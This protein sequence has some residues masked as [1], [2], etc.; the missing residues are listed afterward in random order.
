M[1][2]SSEPQSTIMSRLDLLTRR[3]HE[4]LSLENWLNFPVIV[5]VS[6]GPDSVALLRWVHAVRLEHALPGSNLIVAHFNHRLRG[7]DSDADQQFVCKL[8]E[9]LGGVFRN[10]TSESNAGRAEGDLRNARYQ[11]LE[12]LAIQ[13]GARLIATGHTSDDQAETVLF[14]L[15]RGSGLRGLAGI[16]AVRALSSTTTL[17]RPLLK[18]SRLEV[19]QLL[20][21]LQQ[22]Y[23]I[24]SSNAELDYTRNYL[25]NSLIPELQTRFP[26]SIQEALL[27]ISQQAGETLDFLDLQSEP[28]FPAVLEQSPNHL[29]LDI[30]QWQTLHPTLLKHFLHRLWQQQKWPLGQMTHARWQS[31]SCS[32]QQPEDFR[33]SL[34]GDIEVLRRGSSLRLE[35]RPDRLN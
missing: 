6:G 2:S 25:R 33:W 17:V 29:Q 5:A 14:R 24:D 32:I 8:T 16:Q 34:P 11:F 3:I 27:R 19:L 4:T 10:G 21:E 35:H 9:Q 22:D 28:L 1:N 13:T 15:L 12:D 30:A 31:L 20:E 7:K 18:V 23:R 26:G